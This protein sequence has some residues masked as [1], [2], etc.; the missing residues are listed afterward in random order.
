MQNPKSTDV[1]IIGFNTMD[2]VLT[3][4]QS[5][6][7]DQKIYADELRR[8]AGGQG[9]N[10]AAN[11]AGLGSAVR[12]VGSFG[13]DTWGADARSSLT[14]VGVDTS[15]SITVPDCPNHVAVVVVDTTFETRSIVM[16]KDPRLTPPT[17][18]VTADMLRDTSALY[19][20]GHEY[21]LSIAAAAIA[22]SLGVRVFADLEVVHA[23]CTRLLRNVSE[24][25]APLEILR[26]I[27]GTDDER[28]T[29][30]LVRQLGPTVVIATK[31]D[32]GCSGLDS[33]AT[34]F[35]LP[36]VPADV[37]DTT[38][39]GDAFHAGYVAA[40]LRGVSV[41]DAARWGT[42]AGALACAHPGPRVPADALRYLAAGLDRP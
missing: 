18:L 16:C 37:R 6:R 3:G 23:D 8:H 10:V 15:G 32:A 4:T 11:L 24:L 26:H 21:E 7:P 38:G 39:A 12:Y 19:T 41:V 40:R 30:D 2:L 1:V 31:G 14:D 42:H 13:D 22:A 25:V 36:A 34:F 28:V 20:D 29:L 17:D 5:I 35:T 9:A 27:V 33:Q